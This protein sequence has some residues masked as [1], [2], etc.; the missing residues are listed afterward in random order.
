MDDIL[1]DF[2]YWISTFLNEIASEKENYFENLGLEIMRLSI[3]ICNL[4]SEQ[5]K[6]FYVIILL[7]GIK[8]KT[9]LI[10]TL[11]TNKPSSNLKKCKIMTKK[12][13]KLAENN[14]DFFVQDVGKIFKKLLI[15][16]KNQEGEDLARILNGGRAS[17]ENPEIVDSGA[18]PEE[19]KSKLGPLCHAETFYDSKINQEIHKNSATDNFNKPVACNFEIGSI[20]NYLKEE[21]KGYKNLPDLKLQAIEIGYVMPEP[22][23][24]GS[25]Q[26][27]NPRMENQ[28]KTSINYATSADS[29][30]KMGSKTDPPEKE[31]S[32]SENTSD[33]DAEEID[34]GEDLEEDSEEEW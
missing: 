27:Q 11:G 18:E 29:I 5:S 19:L 24:K 1:V 33:E 6:R 23:T 34:E 30:S 14:A 21:I 3:L 7:F 28:T 26:D 10:A 13:I 22:M 8:L 16:Q 25:D 20:S 32:L 31:D 17:E 4:C 2:I 15:Q 12:L 9:L